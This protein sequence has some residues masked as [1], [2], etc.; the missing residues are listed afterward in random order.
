M[1]YF[2][3]TENGRLTRIDACDVPIAGEEI[4]KVEYDMLKATIQTFIKN[5]SE[6]V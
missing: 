6:E 2:K 3:T 4:S 5:K 1:R